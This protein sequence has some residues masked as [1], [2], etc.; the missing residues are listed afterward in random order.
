MEQL[1]QIIK[2]MPSIVSKDFWDQKFPSL[3][4]DDFFCSGYNKQTVPYDMISYKDENGKVTETRLVFALAGFSK[5]DIDIDV[6]EDYLKIKIN[7]AKTKENDDAYLHKG[8][9]RRS[10]NVAYKL[11][12]VDVKNIDASFE[13]GELS[14]SLPAKKEHTQKV[15]IK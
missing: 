7:K 15:K 1:G 6:S 13:N 14:I 11:F 12:G 8:I 2:F 5:E 4:D 10:I 3:L 9:A